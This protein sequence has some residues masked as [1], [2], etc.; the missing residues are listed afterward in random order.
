MSKNE[1]NVVRMVI[2]E[3]DE[4]DRVLL[5]AALKESK[6]A[7]PVEFVENGE[8]LLEYLRQQ[9]RYTHLEGK[10]HPGLVLLDLNMPRKDGRETLREI[11]NDE[12]LKHIPIVVLTTSQEDNDIIH[13]YGLGANSYITKPTSLEALIDIVNTLDLYWF[14]IVQLPNSDDTL[15]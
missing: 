3:D 1:S 14:H 8:E 9:G 6:F 11:R 15:L 12:R 2:A 10:P 4:D 7:H 13:S 5:Q